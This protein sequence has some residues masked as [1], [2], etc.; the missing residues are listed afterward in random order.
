MVPAEV[1]AVLS[2]IEQQLG[3]LESVVER[4]VEEE[5][6]KWTR[7]IHHWKQALNLFAILYEGRTP[8]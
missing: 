8:K 7:P 3:E 1:Q 4:A 5:G 6:K 2:R